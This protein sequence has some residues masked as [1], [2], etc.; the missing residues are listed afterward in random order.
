MRESDIVL[1]QESLRESQASTGEA[2][3]FNPTIEVEESLVSLLRSRIEKMQEDQNFEQQ[4]KDA[5][6]ARLPEAEFSELLILL[7]SLQNQS[8]ISVEKILSPFIPRVGDRVPILDA[9]KDKDQAS[10]DEKVFE[11]SSQSTLKSINEL[12]KLSRVIDKLIKESSPEEKTL[13]EKT[14]NNADDKN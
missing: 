5:I 12:S 14:N 7:N 3:P 1:A 8:N 6:L 11:Q 4:I 2:I 13:A 10:I 9:A